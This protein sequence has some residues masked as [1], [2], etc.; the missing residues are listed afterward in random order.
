MPESAKTPGD[1]GL[2]MPGFWEN[3][4]NAGMK[5]PII[6][7]RHGSRAGIRAIKARPSCSRAN[8]PA[9]RAAP[10]SVCITFIMGHYHF[11]HFTDRAE[12]GV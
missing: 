3:R 1:G 12:E 8:R 6:I 11:C 7:C 4:G 2:F 5:W 9:R 10:F